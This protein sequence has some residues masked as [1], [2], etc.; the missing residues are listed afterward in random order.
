V[1]RSVLY[2][3]E[4]TW[5]CGWYRCYVPG[6]EL[7]KRGYDVVL[8]STL[9]FE[10]IKRFDVI[11]FQ[12]KFDPRALEAIQLANAFDKLTVYELDDDMWT[13]SPTNPA[14]PAWTHD[15]LSGAVR[16]V[17]ACKLVTTTTPVMADRLRRF[18][19]NVVV[20][21]NML[22]LEGW[23]YPEPKEQREDRVVLGWAGST[24]HYDDMRILEDVVPTLL[25][26]YEQAEFVFVG[27]PKETP[28]AMRDR[29]SRLQATDIQHYPAL[30]EQFD[31]GLIPLVDTA[32]NRAKS[33]LK[34][35]EYSMIGIPSVASKVEP[36]VGTIRH[37]ENGFLA[38]NAKDWIKFAS[39]LI[40]DVAL[41]R[42]IG[43]KAQGFARNRTIDKGIDKWIR[44]FQLAEP[45]AAG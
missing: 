33:N 10:D 38:T 18:N 14:A 7:K 27:G 4:D 12:R 40:E 3:S 41:R 29:V 39:R 32:F 45:P 36:Y 24:S 11:M 28:I 6:V 1:N 19:P 20:V 37:A 30:I 17:R 16:C 26:R 5:A 9:Q 31:I 25:D 34:F 23:E 2:F 8:D 21:P 43:A 22:P 35:L 15:T 42:E 44:A 13:L